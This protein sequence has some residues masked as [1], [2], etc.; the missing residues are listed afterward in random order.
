MS[1]V[2]DTDKPVL[3]M[4][5]KNCFLDYL[6]MLKKHFEK[7]FYDDFDEI[8]WIKN[9]FENAPRPTSLNLNDISFEHY[10]NAKSSQCTLGREI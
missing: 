10:I 1:M 5:L 7:Y 6:V 3:S 8:D 9:P 4:E 2:Q